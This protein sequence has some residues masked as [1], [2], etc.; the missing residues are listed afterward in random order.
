MSHGIPTPAFVSKFQERLQNRQY[1]TERSWDLSEVFRS[2]VIWWLRFAAK[3]LVLVQGSEECYTDMLSGLLFRTFQDYCG[4]FFVLVMTLEDDAWFTVA[5]VLTFEFSRETRALTSDFH[6]WSF[7][8]F[9]SWKSKLRVAHFEFSGG[10]LTLDEDSRHLKHRVAIQERPFAKLNWDSLLAK[11]APQL[12]LRLEHA[13]RR[14]S[15][16]CASPQSIKSLHS[17]MVEDFPR[18][19]SNILWLIVFGNLLRL[20]RLLFT[21]LDRL[22][23][24]D[25]AQKE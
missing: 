24:V 8:C 5:K 4:L 23:S 17:E 3:L 19:L 25:F 1:E 14:R 2:N 20:L 11:V 15:A 22:G 13:R 7:H 18:F 12:L 6:I 21:R 9:I 16:I 10:R